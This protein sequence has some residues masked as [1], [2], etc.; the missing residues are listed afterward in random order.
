[1]RLLEVV[2]GEKTAP[3]V[4]ATGFA[5]GKKMKKVA[6]RSG[7]CDGF[8]GNR[9]L[10]SYL[11]VS[12]FIVE[13]GASPYQIDKA[14]KDFGYPMGPFAMGDL[15]GLDIGWSNRKNKA[16]TRNRNDRYAADFLDRICEK[17]WFGQKTAKGFYVYEGGARSGPPNEEIE[18]IIASVREKKGIEPREFSDEEI[19]RRYLAAMINEAAKVVGEGIALRPLDVD[20]VAL[21]GYGFPRWRGGPM[22]YADHVGLDKILADIREFAKEDSHFWAPAP[23]LVDLVESGRKFEDLNNA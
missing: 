7:V 8:I 13:D 21:F 2:V 17:G 22:H 10:A 4:A 5:L 1:M 15:A 20:M 9:I 3:E 6:V 14:V 11:R 23:L 16:E 12:N 18:P 19:M